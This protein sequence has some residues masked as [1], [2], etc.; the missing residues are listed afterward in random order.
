MAENEK[1]EIGMLRKISSNTETEQSE[2]GM[3]RKILPNG[4]LIAIIREKLGWCIARHGASCD[5]LTHLCCDPM[6][7]RTSVIRRYLPVVK[8]REQWDFLS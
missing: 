8:L 7:L 4:E 1:L 5:G 2:I 6:W 3:S